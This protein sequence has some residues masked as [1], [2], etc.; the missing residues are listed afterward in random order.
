MVVG[1]WWWWW[2]WF[3]Q[4]WAAENKSIHLGSNEQTASFK[5]PVR[6]LS[7]PTGSRWHW[8]TW[9]GKFLVH[10]S[11]G[12]SVGWLGLLNRRAQSWLGFE[13]SFNDLLVLFFSSIFPFF[14]YPLGEQKSSWLPRI[15]SWMMTTMANNRGYFSD[16]YLK[17]IFSFFSSSISID[18]ALMERMCFHTYVCNTCFDNRWKHHQCFVQLYHI[19]RV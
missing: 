7:S 19:I 8:P 4:T 15:R 2:W 5:R 13:K 11:V 18:V 12:R 16:S 14:C 9:Q 3:Q 6:S 17:K 1:W 10:W